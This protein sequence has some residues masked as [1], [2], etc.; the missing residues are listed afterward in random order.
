MP[1]KMDWKIMYLDYITNDHKYIANLL[2]KNMNKSI[3]C[4][5]NI[6]SLIFESLDMKVKAFMIPTNTIEGNIYKNIL[7]SI[8]VP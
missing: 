3:I 4:Y 8:S 7:E 5:M 2:L 1:N 6:S